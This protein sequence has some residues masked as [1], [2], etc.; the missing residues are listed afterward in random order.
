MFIPAAF[1]HKKNGSH[2][3]PGVKEMTDEDVTSSGKKEERWSCNGW[4][5]KMNPDSRCC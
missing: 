4:K 2:S 1:S 5:I 3:Y